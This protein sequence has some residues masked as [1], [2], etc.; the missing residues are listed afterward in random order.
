M[1]DQ[2]AHVYYIDTEI[3]LGTTK[4]M[5]IAYRERAHKYTHTHVVGS[6]KYVRSIETHW[7]W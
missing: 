3:R 4:S 5:K 7:K 6:T 1:F 2:Q